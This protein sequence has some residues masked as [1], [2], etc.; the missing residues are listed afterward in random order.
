MLSGPDLD[1]L[2]VVLEAT[3]IDVIASGGV[4]GVSDVAALAALRSTSGRR[5]AGAIVGKAIYEGRMSVGEGI[6]ACAASV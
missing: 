2:A 1:G 3:A 4:S 5:L 6:A